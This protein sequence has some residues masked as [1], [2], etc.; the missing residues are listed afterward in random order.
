VG[1]GLWQ[2]CRGDPRPGKQHGKSGEFHSWY[3]ETGVQGGFYYPDVVFDSTYWS[4]AVIEG[5]G[6][7]P[8]APTGLVA[9]HG[10]N[11]VVLSWNTV[12]GAISYNV[13]RSTSSGGEATIANVS[14][15][16]TTGPLQINTLTP[17]STTGKTYY[18]KVSAV[19]TNGESLN[20]V[21]VSATPPAVHLDRPWIG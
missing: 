20:S 11:Q 5:N 12:P 16:T 18:Y 4:A 7:V 21:E 13:K 6:A 3:L 15:P 19:N 8:A 1:F 10:E 9:T 14:T 2:R 17:G